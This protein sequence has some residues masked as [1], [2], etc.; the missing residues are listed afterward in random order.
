MA[1]KYFFEAPV[2]MTFK[3]SL[4]EVNASV[5]GWVNHARYGNTV[6]LR[7]AVLGKHLIRLAAHR[8]DEY[9]L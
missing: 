5:Q 9:E 3:I 8:E 7:R 2:E 4:A 1:I 6:G